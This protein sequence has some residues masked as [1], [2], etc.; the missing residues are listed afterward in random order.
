MPSTDGQFEDGQSYGGGSGRSAAAPPGVGGPSRVSRPLASGEAVFGV[1]GAMREEV[2]ALVGC[3]AGASTRTRGPFVLH[4]GQIDGRRVMVAECGI[5]KANAAALTQA[6]LDAGAD[7]I[8]C[9]GVAGAVHEG[10]AVGDVVVARDAVQHDVDVTA[11]GYALGEVPADGAAWP[12]DPRLIEAAVEAAREAAAVD[13][14]P[15]RVVVG[16]VA[17]GD[18]FVASA[19]KVAWLRKTFDAACA[20]M[21]GAAVAQVCAKWGAPFVIVRSISDTADHDAQVD[22]R[23]FTTLAAARA[24]DVVQGLLR[25]L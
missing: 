18:T 5:G 15:P 13:P 12:A 19:A 8:V 20:E 6:L 2:E 23:A 17:S 22:F 1:I 3:L 10:L 14:E 4:A 16:R 25:R 7:A 9:T 11:L 24:A 21:E